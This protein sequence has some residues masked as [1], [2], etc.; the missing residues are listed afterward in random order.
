MNAKVEVE[1]VPFYTASSFRFNIP[2]ET[3]V[4]S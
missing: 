2:G 4:A 1:A 3:A